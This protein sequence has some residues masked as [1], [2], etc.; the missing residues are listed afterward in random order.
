[1]SRLGRMLVGAWAV[2]AVLL[3]GVAILLPAAAAD[4]AIPDAVKDGITQALQKKVGDLLDLKDSA[5]LSNV[6]GAYSRAYKRVD[7]STY[8]VSFEKFIAERE[9][10]KVERYLLTLKKNASGKWEVAKEEL[11][12]AFDGLKRVNRDR[13]EYQAFDK[14]TFEKY[15]MKITATKGSAFVTY[16]MDKP[17]SV[18]VVA[19]DLAYEYTPPKTLNYFAAYRGIMLKEYPDE[20]VFKPEQLIIRGDG[21]SMAG[22][23]A[24]YFTGLKKTSKDAASPKLQKVVDDA[25]RDWNK[26]MKD[27]PFFG[28]RTP[29]RDDNR[30]WNFSLKRS[31]GEELWLW[32]DYDNYEAWDVNFGNSKRGTVFGYYSDELLASG[33]KPY[34][35]ERREDSEARWYDLDSLVGS[36]DIGLE[37]ESTIE[38]DFNYELTIK[39]KVSDLPFRI[40]RLRQPG[41]EQAETKQPKMTIN[42]LQDGDGNDLTWVKTGPFSARIIFPKALEP[43]Q[44]LKLRMAF[45]NQD[46]VYK[47]NPSYLAMDRLGWIPFVRF[48]DP[49][50]HFDMTVRVKSKYR[51]LGPGKKV[52]EKK[53]NGCQVTRWT[54]ANPVSFPTVIF[55]DYFDDGPSIKATRSDGTEIPVRVYVDKVS[56]NTTDESAI[57]S[58]DEYIDRMAKLEGGARG[59][60]LKNLPAVA[61][62]AVNALNLYRVVL[63]QEYKYDKLDLVDDPLG[64]FYGQAPASIIYLGFG[65]FWGEGRVASIGG[66]DI[67]KFNKDVVAHETGHQWWGGL[68]G[69]ANE[70]NYWFVESLTEYMSA[71]YVQE[72]RGAKAYDD[73]IAAWRRTIMEYELLNSVQNASSL[74]GGESAGGAYLANVYNRGP[75]AF[76]VMRE[77]Y[78][79]EK[80]YA[81]LK[82]LAATFAEKQMVTLDIQNVAEKV[83]GP[84][85]PM[86]FDQ[87]FRGIGLPQF[88]LMWDVRPTEDGK[89]LVDGKIRQ[90]VIAGK[91][92]VEMPGV[93]YRSRGW[94]TF[95]FADGKQMKYPAAPKSATEQVK[96][97][98]VDGPETPFKVKLPEK[99]VAVYFNKD[100]EIL[101][102]DTLVNQ[103]W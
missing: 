95:E 42:I 90:R 18:T 62:Q 78:G 28:F 7:D 97:F 40:S 73:K 30:T 39:Q 54:S 49:V 84:S 59:I 80:F 22:I 103:S 2:S 63:G 9:V 47:V 83:L 14:L 79:D 69:N 94:L 52:M 50:D 3:V 53:E 72:S 35:L 13:D 31:S 64:S 57:R 89:F 68:V 34:E 100:G 74:W 71:L 66:S 38:G 86:F 98:L 10:E 15:G 96:A 60:R 26:D 101:A 65:V 5:G 87:W 70:R 82:E 32:M 43:G 102:H 24:T 36:V 99:P 27:N 29:F 61:D 93:Y 46:S 8:T 92:E 55:G 51:A 77:T 88:A 17:N 11:Q 91:K 4:D 41:D 23:L 37:D 19:D 21:E 56:T 76:H 25:L 33:I 81:F 67:T 6:R 48:T 44:K 16:F 20:F 12:H 58:E 85:I 45:R 75:Y 1:M